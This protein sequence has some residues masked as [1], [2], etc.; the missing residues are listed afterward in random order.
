M[1][2]FKWTFSYQRNGIGFLN[3]FLYSIFKLLQIIEWDDQSKKKNNLTF[4]IIYK[5]IKES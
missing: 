4:K 5:I 1:M 3:K 2:F